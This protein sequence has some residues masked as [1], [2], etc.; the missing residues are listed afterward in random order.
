MGYQVVFFEFSNDAKLQTFNSP[1][2]SFFKNLLLK[3]QLI[4]LLKQI[5]MEC[6][7]HVVGTLF[8]ERITTSTVNI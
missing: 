4:F 3:D 5:G 7:M 8:G 2:L 1:Y 6:I